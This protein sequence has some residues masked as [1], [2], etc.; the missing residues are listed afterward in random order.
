MPYQ[1]SSTESF[2]SDLDPFFVGIHLSCMTQS[3]TSWKHQRLL[4]PGRPKHP[5]QVRKRKQTETIEN[6][7]NTLWDTVQAGQLVDSETNADP[8]DSPVGKDENLSGCALQEYL[9]D[10]GW[11]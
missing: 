5:E 6:P 7:L 1:N 9:E 8:P 10:R 11:L 3:L 2:G 4:Q